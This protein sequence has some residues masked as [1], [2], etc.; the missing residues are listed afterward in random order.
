[1]ERESLVVVV[2]LVV[3]STVAL[4]MER[5]WR[6]RVVLPEQEG[7]E[8]VRRRVRGVEG[9]GIVILEWEWQMCWWWEVGSGSG[10]V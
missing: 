4:K 5:R 6:A 1:M 8:R 7:P 2:V 3:V 10:V 9:G